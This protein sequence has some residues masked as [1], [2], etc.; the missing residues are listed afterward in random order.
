M[1][2]WK[3]TV[4]LAMCLGCLSGTTLQ[5]GAVSA[6]AVDYSSVFDAQYYA[7]T[8]T[9]VRHAIGN[10]ESKL[11]E[12]FI[13]SGMKEGRVAKM[14]F[15]VH[16]YMK[17]NLDLI[18][19]YGIRD[20]SKYYYHYIQCGKEEG[21]IAT[22]KDAPVFKNEIASFSTKYNTEEARAINVELA[23]QRI[24]G[25][26]IQPGETFSFS[27]SIM[28]RTTE[29][30][31]VMAPSFAAGK[32]VSS[33]GGGICQVSSTLYV[34]MLLSSIPATQRYPH[35]LQV[36]Y[37]PEGLDAAIVEGVK[38]LRFKNPFDYPI[39]ICSTAKNGTLTVGI[40]KAEE[41]AKTK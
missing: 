22:A 29:N 2:K 7:N 3:R 36:D 5:A 40:C 25:I 14:D 12:H 30:G 41:E 19:V 10:N 37:V 11:L 13:T 27:N 9:D 26:V 8:Y 39:R 4:A 1:K 21:R 34:T 38:D 24:N 20:L 6:T 16:A 28:S 17:N 35:S 31:Y 15:D 32:V 33:V 18:T 23:S